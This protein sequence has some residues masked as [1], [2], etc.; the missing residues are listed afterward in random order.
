MSSDDL[1]LDGN[2]AAGL[3]AEGVGIDLTAALRTCPH[4]RHRGPL[5][6]HHAYLAAPGAVLRCPGCDAVAIRLVHTRDRYVIDLAGT[7]LLEI[8]LPANP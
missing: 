7:L 5:G 6:A 2:A 3:I 4:C 8:P 1:R